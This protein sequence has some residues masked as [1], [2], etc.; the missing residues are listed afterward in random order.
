MMGTLVEKRCF[1]KSDHKKNNNKF[2]NVEVYDDGSTVVHYGRVGDSGTR[3]TKQW[4]NVSSAQNFATKKI[5]E[6]TRSGRNGEIA[7]RE[8]EIIDNGSATKQAVKTVASSNLESIAKNQIKYSNPNVASL[9][10]YLTKVNAHN[11]T[12]A[13]GGQI[14]FNDTTGLFSTPLG[15]VTQSNIDEANNILVKIGDYVAKGTYGS[16]LGDLTNDYLMLVPQDIGRKRLDIRSFWSDLNKVQ[17]QKSIVDSLQ[18]SLVTAT[19]DK[20]RK[21]T[22][23][24]KEEQVFDVQ[25]DLIEDSKIIDH[26]VNY[27]RNSRKS[28]HSCSHYEVKTVYSVDIRTVR[29]AFEQDGAKMSNIWE[30]WHGSSASNLLSIL[31][32]GLIIPPKTSSNV[33][34]RMFSDGV[35]ASNISTKAL[36]YATGFWGK[37]SDRAFM[38]LLDMAMGN[39]HVPSGPSSNLPYRGSDSTFAKPG[40]S[41]IMNEE[42]I[43]YRT[44]QINLKYLVEFTPYG[45]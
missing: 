3:Q 33:T 17:N 38:F 19:T 35:Y 31:K 6:K 44:S 37:S 13:T 12:S 8:I 43:V 41:G 24:Q 14:T 34:G 32:G 39:Y 21:K 1:V 29:E 22:V 16:R 30:L 36:G 5:R 23:K 20:S 40:K 25:L 11:I 9:I 7:Y 18:A 2:W 4:G 10:S 28:M 45:R 26:A 42:M 27:Y 15:I